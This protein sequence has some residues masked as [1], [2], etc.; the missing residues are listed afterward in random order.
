MSTNKTLSRRNFMKQTLSAGVA[1]AAAPMILPSGVLAA[2]GRPGA[3]DKIGVAVIGPGRMGGSLMGQY[4]REGAELVA[5]ADCYQARLDQALERFPN[6]KAYQHYRDLLNDPNV[7][8][9]MVATPDHWHALNTVHACEAGKDVYVEKPMSLTI[10]EGQLMVEAAAK[11]GRVV[12]TGSMQR[13]MEACR[14]GCELVRNGRAG[15][16]ESV[17]TNNY[18][19]PWECELPAQPVPEGL[20]WDFWCGQTEP[21][22]YHEHLYLPRGAGERDERGPLGWISYRPYSGGEVTGW[23]THGLDLI[24]WALG[25]DESGPVELWPEDVEEGLWSKVSFR[26]ANGVT[27]HLDGTGPMGG[28]RFVGDEGEIMVDRGRY[29]GRP[30]SILEPLGDDDVK[31]EVSTDHMQN[32]LDCIRTREQPITNVRVGHSTTNLCHLINITRWLG[33]KLQWDPD[34]EVFVN[35]EEANN[36]LEREMRNPYTF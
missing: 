15:K 24:Q 22:P 25:E 10:R 35:D 23:G 33:R 19:S 6:A 20:N 30:E 13:S 32:W 29:D 11:Y 28:G 12:T 4:P 31:L 5:F 26:Y 27:V 3:N 8:A 9:V 18:P 36:L 21:R 1:L 7:D 34:I 16:I 2:Q 17:H 14:I